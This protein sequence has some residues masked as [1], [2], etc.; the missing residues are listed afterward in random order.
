MSSTSFHSLDISRSVNRTAS[1]ASG[2]NWRLTRIDPVLEPPPVAESPLVA[3][4]G[5]ATRAFKADARDTRRAVGA[6][7]RAH[8]GLL[9]GV[10]SSPP[11][12]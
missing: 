8:R 6:G 12:F 2:Q 4:I 5:T 1:G 3:A 9:S 11:G 10:P 7:G